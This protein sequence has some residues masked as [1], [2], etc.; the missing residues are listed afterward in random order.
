MS[1][2]RPVTAVDPVVS[3]VV[4]SMPSR[5]RG[6][7][8]ERLR[9]QSLDAPYEVLV[10]NDP[11]VDRCRARNRGLAV[12]R[13]DVVAFTDDDCLPPVDWLATVRSAFDR[14]PDLVCVEGPV[15]GGCRY[16]GTRRYLGCN[17]AVRR[18][19]AL[20]AGGFRSEYA[21][22]R[23]DTEFGWRMERRGRC[24]YLPTMRM[25]HPTVPRTPLDPELERRLREEYP[26]RYAAVIGTDL[27]GRLYRRARAAGLTAVVNRLLN[28]FRST[29]PGGH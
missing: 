14:D 8:M 5:D 29:R 22:W 9:A 25:C 2:E 20:D 27:P 23:E 15:F 26:E 17:V 13:S 3:V 4:P 11:D 19:A 24:R 1:V 6:D 21:A 28:R 16:D 10:V 7:L 12:A 18:D